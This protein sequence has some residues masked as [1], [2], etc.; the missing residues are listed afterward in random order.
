[1]TEPATEKATGKAEKTPAPKPMGAQQRRDLGK[2]IDAEIESL[3]GE[4]NVFANELSMRRDREI[5]EEFEE[6]ERQARAVEAEWLN[7]AQG[8]RRQADE[9]LQRKRNEGFYIS[10]AGRYGD[11]QP[12]TINSIKITVPAKE[13]AKKDA[14]NIV[15]H[16]KMTAMQGLERQ[17]LALQKD[18]LLDGLVSDK[19]KEFLSRMPNPR[20]LLAQVMEGAREAGLT[21]RPIPQVQVQAIEG[22]VQVHH[23]HDEQ[24]IHI[25]EI[26]D[27]TEEVNID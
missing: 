16:Q 5:E 27:P 10:G 26:L 24:A 21:P 17:R 13:R 4:L 11:S 1:M 12:I 14:Q 19:A 15:S 7:F 3:K 6:Q 23:A 2:L 9:W 25:G 20:E 22:G 18:V 8:L